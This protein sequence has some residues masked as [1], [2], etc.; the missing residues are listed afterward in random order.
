MKKFTLFFLLAFFAFAFASAQATETA[1]PNVE[2]GPKGIFEWSATTHDFGDIDQ[3]IPVTHRFS[4]KNTGTVPLNVK[5]VKR[6]CGCTNTDWSKE[7]IAPGAEGFVEA[8]FNAA[9]PGK[10]HKGITVE[11]D[12]DT[13]FMT[14]FFEGNV[15]KKE[16]MN[17]NGNS[18]MDSG[19]PNNQ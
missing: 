2:S 19:N 1:D 5:E 3:G 16:E 17:L 18:I 13:P 9:A 14:I 6:T 8:T 15:V 10:F 7:P 11:S 12:S 4:F